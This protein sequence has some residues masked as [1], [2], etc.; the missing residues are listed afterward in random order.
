MNELQIKLIETLRYAAARLHKSGLPHH[1]SAQMESLVEQVEQPCVV[2]VVGRVKAGKSTF[3]NALLG[4]DLAKVGPTETTATINFFRYGTPSADFPVR[5][6]WRSGKV[7][8]ENRQFLDN[9]QGNDLETLHRADGINYLEYH[10]PN[11]HL[12][13]ITLVDTP[14]TGAVVDEHQNRT[15]EFMN[16]YRQ[17]RERH[18]QETQRIGNAADAVIYLIG[19]T[20]RITDQAFLDEFRQA[21]QGQSRALNAIGVMA[22][23]DLSAEVIKRK[24]ELSAKIAQQLQ[25]SLNTVIP[26]SAGI[27]RALVGLLAREHEQLKQMMTML[28]TIPRSTLEEL[29]ADPELYQEQDCSIS[30]G[31]RAQLRAG[32]P[33]R[34][35]V[36]IANIVTDPDLDERSVVDKLQ[37]IAGFDQLHTILDKHFIRRGTLLRAHRIVNDAL[38]VVNT[39]KFTY[40][41]EYHRRAAED[42]IK[43][44]RFLAFL[45]SVQ[46]YSPVAVELQAFVQEHLAHQSDLGLLIAEIERAIGHIKYELED[47]N[48]D[49]EALQ[50][51]EEHPVLFSPQELGE[52]RPLFGLHGLEIGKRLSPVHATLMYIEERQ[53]HW[54]NKSQLGK[55]PIIRS[56]AEHAVR[57]YGLLVEEL[58]QG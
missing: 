50:Q 23:I 41:H 21:T 7:T 24:E 2:A 14:G 40:L 32:M 39:V 12:E 49:F 15:A 48:T 16:L 27:Q 58:G 38:L 8:N 9:L 36:T 25:H 34:V 54:T 56:I 22:K 30:S 29:L 26:V 19:E 17:L 55:D 35:F 18:H 47:Y 45:R 43:Q 33:W 53:T 5:C 20:A 13:Q 11:P 46:S 31:E 52:L 1:V 10:L 4:D 37:I 6:Y 42:R 57:R 28:R 3:I 44:E 51:V